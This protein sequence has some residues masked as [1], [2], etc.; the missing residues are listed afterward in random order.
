MARSPSKEG[1]TLLVR[2][3]AMSLIGVPAKSNCHHVHVA[4]LP[5]DPQKAPHLHVAVELNREA[6]MFHLN[7]LHAC[8]PRPR[9]ACTVME[10]QLQ[11]LLLVLK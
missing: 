6:V 3:K 10:N 2:Q 1:G 4:A 11:V 5:W 9:A 7:G 8:L